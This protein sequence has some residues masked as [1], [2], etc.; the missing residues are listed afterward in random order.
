MLS[1]PRIKQ[2]HV[3]TQQLSSCQKPGHLF[4]IEVRYYKCSYCDYLRL[5]STRL[6]LTMVD[7]ESVIP[8]E[9]SFAMRL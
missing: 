7:G 2:Y 9:T 5:P 6:V 4:A 3:S 1:T 8:F